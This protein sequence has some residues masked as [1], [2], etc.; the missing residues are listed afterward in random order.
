MQLFTLGGNQ[1]FRGFDMAERQG[2]QVWLGSLEWRIPVVQR[3][4]VSVCDHAATVRSLQIVPFSDVGAA[5]VRGE[6]VGGNIA[7][8]LGLGLRVGVDLFSYLER[9]MLRF[10]VAKTI[11]SP[12]PVQFWF[13]VEHPF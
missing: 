11:D 7:Y 13:G 3:A 10:D 6:P 5:Y 1:L 2:S 12:A 8:A 4:E 9:A